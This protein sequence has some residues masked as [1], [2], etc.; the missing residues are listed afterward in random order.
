MTVTDT[1]PEAPEAPEEADAEEP[2]PVAAPWPPATDHKVI[3][4]IFVVV[5]VLSLV[6]SGAI[7]LVM[8]AQLSGPDMDIVGRVTYGELFTLHGTL[9][10]FGFLAPV[11]VG[12]ATAVV[13]LQI[14]AARLAFPRLQA[15]CLW[16]I[17]AG[18]AMMAASPFVK[19]GD[20]V[21]GW[22][23]S[24][25]IP[26]GPAFR[27]NGPDLLILGLGLVSVALVLAFT[28]LLVTVVKLRAPGLTLRRTPLFSWSV[29]VAGAVVL[30]ALPVLVAGLG[31][32]F[33]D[34]HYGGHI[35]RGFTGS[36]GGNPNV[37]PRLFW[38]AAYPLLWALLLPALGAV[39][40][41]VAT[42]ARRR[43][44][45]HARAVAAVGAVGVLAFAGWGS[46]TP[47]L[48]RARLLFGAGA[49]LVLAPVASLVLNWLATLV[50]GRCQRQASPRSL[51][52]LPM[53]VALGFVTVLVVG[54]GGGA[55]A[56]L[57]AGTSSHRNY[58]QVAT[59]HTLFFGA[60]TLGVVAALAYWAPKLWGRH[61]S[62]K[63]GKLTAVLLVGGMHL[64]FL[65][66]FVLGIQNMRVHLFTY[67]SGDDFGPANLVATVGAVVTVLGVAVLA[68]DLLVSVI[69]RRGRRADGDPW[70]GHTLEWATSSP[71]P[72]HN[73][74]RLPEIRSEAPLLDLRT[75]AGEAVG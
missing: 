42:F 33:M 17:V 1:P 55:I 69:A 38:F 65:P 4:T 2:A 46:E 56:A 28:N 30:L 59:Q 26:E 35:F 66:M 7:A 63:G 8:R 31:M 49:L 50:T 23:L 52:A 64:T 18:I 12:L 54:L 37:W 53:V 75:A 5:A 40:D 20:V 58:W 27:G 71:P 25:P 39:S 70:Q 67:E 9:A 3:G 34:R 68:L 45:S 21:S 32:L 51:A 61:L 15:L 74:D 44:F 47:G 48:S 72:G 13:P 10:V 22:A 29:L 57:T 41:I 19:G 14:G 43:L 60:A 24:S 36:L 11:W 62:D 6:V 16:V 73:F